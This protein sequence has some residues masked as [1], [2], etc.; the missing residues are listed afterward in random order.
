MLRISYGNFLKKSEQTVALYEH[1]KPVC[2][3]G[4]R[5][6]F[7]LTLAAFLV[8]VVVVGYLYVNKPVKTY[9]SSTYEAALSQTNNLAKSIAV[10]KDSRPNGIDV[11]SVI[12]AFVR[13]QGP[14]IDFKK[15]SITPKKYVLTAWTK[16]M[17]AANKYTKGLIFD[18]GK[19]IQISTVKVVEDTTEF[20]VTVMDKGK[21]VTK[22]AK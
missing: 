2:L 8:G 13:E 7:V 1:N 14:D 15:I 11:C 20:L 3:L 9:D 18:D 6:F 21:P 17:G 16:N 10:Y 4:C 22:G 12:E 19:T 5:C